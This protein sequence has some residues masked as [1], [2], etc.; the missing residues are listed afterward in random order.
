MAVT[1]CGSHTHSGPTV[2]KGIGWGELSPEFRE[3]WIE[4]AVAKGIEAFENEEKIS[5]VFYGKSML[6]EKLGMNRVLEDG[7]TDPEIRWIKF[8][9]PDGRTK[10]L[11]HN[12]AMHG[13]VF[14]PANLLV[15]AD[16]IGAVNALIINEG[17]AEDTIFLQGALGN[18]NTVPV[19][20]NDV[21]E[22]RKHIERISASYVKSLV[23]GLNNETEM[24]NT[25]IAFLSRDF[26]LPV[27]TVTPESLRKT[28]EKLATHGRSK[29]L[30]DRLQEMAL[31]IEAG[32]SIDV[33]AELQVLKIGEAVVY[34]IP[35]EP[36]LELGM[37]LMAKSPGFPVVAAIANGNCRYFPTEDIFAR[38]SDI[39]SQPSGGYYEIHQG[40]GRFMPE[41]QDNISQFIIEKLLEIVAVCL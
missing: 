2:S 13:V 39:L 22:G 35:G 24:I 40:C 14:G 37:E 4:L 12:H 7:P 16:W 9:R 20:V 31:Y 30:I 21:N 25:N 5:A 17:I 27:K 26:L 8:I 6:K 3:K 38:F 11:I 19:C 1:V 41:Y 18:I 28:A 32:N 23:A 29:F 34:A 15:S 36:F 33:M 10:L